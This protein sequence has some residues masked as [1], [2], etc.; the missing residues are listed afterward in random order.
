MDER[1]ETKDPFWSVAALPYFREARAAGHL[2]AMAYSIRR[3]LREPETLRW[4]ADHAEAVDKFHAWSGA[5]KPVG[6]ASPKED[7]GASP[8][9]E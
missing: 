2:E 7:A 1:A 8:P 5:W 6:P 9:G 3:S 4:L